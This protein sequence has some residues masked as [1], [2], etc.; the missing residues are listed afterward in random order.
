[1]S[2]SKKGI[3]I[4]LAGL[5]IISSACTS[6][7]STSTESPNASTAATAAAAQTGDAQNGAD[8]FGKAAKPITIKIERQLEY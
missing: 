1:M 2:K 6:K 4:L 3:H 5:M 8:P 7:T